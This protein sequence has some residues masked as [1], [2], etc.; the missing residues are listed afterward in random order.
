[1][2]QPVS[3]PFLLKISL[4]VVT[5]VKFTSLLAVPYLVVDRPAGT[6]RG[7]ATVTL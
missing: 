3:S 7:E 1:M 2:D 4:S 5:N 6:R